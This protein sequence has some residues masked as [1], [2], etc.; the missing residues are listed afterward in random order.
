MAGGPLTGFD[1]VAAPR[2]EV[3]LGVKGHHPVDPAQRNS[4]FAADALQ[5]LFRQITVETL[6]LLENGDERSIL[7]MFTEYLLKPAQI[8]CFS[9]F[10]LLP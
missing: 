6:S 10:S 7:V 5:N 4:Q 9:H 1:D 2:I 8:Q 3:E